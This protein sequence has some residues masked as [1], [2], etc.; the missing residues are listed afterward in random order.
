MKN[1]SLL[2]GRVRK[3]IIDFID[4]CYRKIVN[5][6]ENTPIKLD[7]SSCLKSSRVHKIF[8]ASAL[9]IHA[10]SDDH[11]FSGHTDYVQLNSTTDS[12]GD[13]QPELP[14]DRI[15]TQARSKMDAVFDIKQKSDSYL[16]GLGAR[17][18]AQ[19]SR[20]ARTSEDDSESKS[21]TCVALILITSTYSSS[22]A[23]KFFK[24]PITLSYLPTTYNTFISPSLCL[25]Q[26]SFISLAFNPE[27]CY[28]HKPHPL[29]DHPQIIPIYPNQHFI[30]SLRYRFIIQVFG[31]IL[32]PAV[33][34]PRCTST[35]LDHSDYHH[36]IAIN[37]AKILQLNLS[38]MASGSLSSLTTISFDQSSMTET[39]D[40]CS[41]VEVAY[42]KS[43]THPVY[44]TE[45]DFNHPTVHSA[46]HKDIFNYSHQYRH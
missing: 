3:L 23:F 32:D 18:I 9:R 39:I 42:S 29:V 25:F 2:K 4:P 27:H 14:A 37:K 5:D 7:L 26:P 13:F 6:F 11:L 1:S 28:L 17:H 34:K 35:G 24:S 43:Y 33:N 19:F 8:H 44:T 45:N 22:P 21:I 41:L 20:S 16:L 15:Q 40:E 30:E 31:P 12:D 36:Q 46:H 38:S 10:T